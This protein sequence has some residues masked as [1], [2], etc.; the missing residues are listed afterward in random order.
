MIH[1]QHQL[2]NPGNGLPTVD[3]IEFVDV[4]TI[5]RIEGEGNY[6]NIYFDN[7]AQLLV[8]KSLVEFEGL[9]SEY[10]FIWVHK[11]H[12]VNVKQIKAFLKSD[13]ASLQLKNGNVIP[14]SRRRRDFVLE[15]LKLTQ[16]KAGFIII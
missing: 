5:T 15:K 10:D 11:A 1:K 2:A 13:G 7:G 14:V 4:Y 8:A 3:K 9:L 16:T 12:A 6:S